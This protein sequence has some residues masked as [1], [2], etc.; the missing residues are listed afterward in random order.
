MHEQSF[1]TPGGHLVKLSCREGTNDRM[2]AESVIEH[3]EYRSRDLPMTE[4]VVVDVGSHIGSWLVMMLRDHKDM[5]GIAVE[6]LTANVE[7]LEANLATN[8]LTA[9]ILQGVLSKG[10]VKQKV[11]WNFSGDD[12]HLM[13]RYIGGQRMPANTP[14]D[15]ELAKPY[16]VAAIVKAAG[17]EVA[18]LKTDCEGGE[19][20]LIGSDLS[21]IRVIVGEYHFAPKELVA[22]LSKTH[23]VIVEGSSGLGSIIAIRK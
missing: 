23:D 19:K 22:H 13:H 5:T 21:H 18:V 10:K 16:S 12:L 8:R 6:P 9:T 20:A 1:Q 14:H 3:D 2:V 11:H 15:V 7:V 17:G 4:G